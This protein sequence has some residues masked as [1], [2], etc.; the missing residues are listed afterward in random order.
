[1]PRWCLHRQP[2]NSQNLSTK[3]AMSSNAAAISR[4]YLNKLTASQ[5]WLFRT[6]WDAS[7]EAHKGG[8][9]AP[10]DNL[11]GGRSI[12]NSHDTGSTW[13]TQGWATKRIQYYSWCRSYCR[14][15]YVRLSGSHSMYDCAA[16][17]RRLT[18]SPSL[19]SHLAVAFSASVAKNV[20]GQTC[21]WFSAPLWGK[22]RGWEMR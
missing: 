8:K 14:L 18:M 9:L 19:R 15:A 11:S 21:W 20:T 17:L 13:K 4:T 5:C 12:D 10:F 16:S 7:V 22:G 3:Q 1:M 2:R 6:I